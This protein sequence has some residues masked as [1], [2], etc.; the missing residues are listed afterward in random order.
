MAKNLILKISE[1]GAKKTTSS[2]KKV[3]SAVAFISKASAIAG[4]GVATLSTKLA[5]D[6][7]QFYQ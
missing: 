7:E 3:G 5:G 4:A 2:L 6:F 1:K